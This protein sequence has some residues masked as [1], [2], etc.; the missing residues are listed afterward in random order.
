MEIALIVVAL[1]ALVAVIALFRAIRQRDEAA[2]VRD[3]ASRELSAVKAADQARMEQIERA[4]QSLDTHFKG[5]AAEVLSANSEAFLKQAKEQFASQSKLSES[6]LEKRQQAIDA[7][8]KPVRENLEKFERRVNEIEEKRQGAYE[9]LKTEVGLLRDVT[10]NLGEAL[11]SS[12]MRG[13]WGEQQLR[14]VLELSGMSERIDFFEQLTVGSGDSTGRPDAVVRVPGGAQVVIDAK[15]PL[16][17]YLE[18]HNTSDDEQRQQELLQSHASSLMGHAR[19]LGRRD[20][21]AAISGSPDFV[22]MF[23]PADP[24]LDSAMDVKPTLWQ[25]AWDKHQ[26]LIATPGLLLAF[27]K[28]VAL[29]W[30]EQSLQENARQITD[31]SKE[32]YDRLRICLDHVAKMGRGLEQAVN[33]YNAGI[34]SLESRVLP[35]ARR[36]EELDAATAKKIAAPSPVE[37]V[38]RQLS[39]PELAEASEVGPAPPNS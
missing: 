26:V 33:S 35:Q 6:D 31:A 39:A 10:G 27:L 11:R 28:T 17:S 24:I 5:M 32:L 38:A 19:T 1:V 23:V 14:N 30:K 9:G 21:D 3:E 15:T 8:V 22:V 7:L 18:A 16:D 25:E 20:Y 29:A 13:H 34:G 2:R 4:R 36:L 12:Q 37:G